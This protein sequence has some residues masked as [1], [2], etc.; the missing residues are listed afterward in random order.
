MDDI[1][2]IYFESDLGVSRE[3][4]R[5]LETYAALLSK[6][7]KRINLVSRK[8]LNDVW[9]RHF[10]DSAQ[11]LS[12]SRDDAKKWVDLGSGAGFPGLVVAILAAELR[13]ELHVTLI[14]S[15]QRKGVFLE[16]VAREVNVSVTIVQKRVDEVVCVGADIISARALAPLTDLLKLAQIHAAKNCQYLFLK[17]ENY[18]SELTAARAIWHIEA[19]VIPSITDPSSV[20]LRI[21]DF[22]LAKS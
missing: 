9:K 21:G 19:D 4:L 10:L 15:D 22:Q 7:N 3:T 16:T 6:W 14:D 20:V 18:E 2:K 12:I 5:K 17:G 1:G 8:S 11:L 13:P